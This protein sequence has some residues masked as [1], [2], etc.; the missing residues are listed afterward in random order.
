MK[1]RDKILK[2]RLR[3]STHIPEGK[4]KILETCPKSEEI[5][6]I[7]PN[8]DIFK[9]FQ[10]FIAIMARRTAIFW[11]RHLKTSISLVNSYN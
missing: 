7:N 10:I 5:I 3:L 1:Y 6:S 8:N 2:P 11:L 9:Y 4:I